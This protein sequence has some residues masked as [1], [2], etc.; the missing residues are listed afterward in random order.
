MH[1]VADWKK[2]KV[3]ELEDLTNSHEIIGIVNLADIPAK[4]LQ[5]MRKSLGDNAILKMS[6]KNFIKIALENSDKEEVEG[7]ADYLEGQPAMVFTKMNPFKLFK[8]L[9]DSKTE[10]PAKAG[11]I[12]PADIVVPAGDTSFPPGPILGELQQVGI[13]AKIDKGSIVVTDDAKIV[14]EGEEIPKAVADI[15]TKLEIHPMEVGIDLLA[16]CEGDT[17]YTADVLA[18]DEEETIQTLANA[19]QS[20]I[21]LSVYA[22]ILNSESAPLLI[23]KAA[24]DALNLAINA[25]ILTSETTDKILSKAYAQMLAVAKLLSSEAID[26]EL[27]EKLNSQ[28]AAAPVAVEDN[29]EEPEEE[30]EEEEDAAE[31]AAAGLGAL[32]G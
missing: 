3:A 31:S 4:Q 27:N 20:A 1:H 28:A 6:R 32:F 26:D 14:D 12:A 22:G 19:Y 5:T 30:E 16:V 13:P 9:E 11:S 25:N 15:L 8:I 2:E 18:I 7:L 17:I 23:Q 21:N 10:A 29:T 24:R